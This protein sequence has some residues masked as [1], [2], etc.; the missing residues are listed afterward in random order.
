MR[1]ATLHA[2]G[3]KWDNIATSAKA[4]FDGHLVGS[5]C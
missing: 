2:V 5:T 3:D 1:K 4:A